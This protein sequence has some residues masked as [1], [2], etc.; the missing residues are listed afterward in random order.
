MTVKLQYTLV[1]KNRGVILSHEEFENQE[2]EILV[3]VDEDGQE[4]PF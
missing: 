4:H 3:L 2:N 1:C